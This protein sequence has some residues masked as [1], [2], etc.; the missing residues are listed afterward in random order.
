MSLVGLKASFFV[1]VLTIVAVFRLT[2]IKGRYLFIVLRCIQIVL[3]YVYSLQKYTYRYIFKPF[4]H[5]INTGKYFLKKR[6]NN[7]H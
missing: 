2:I 6:N 5:R 1:G 4:Y 3:F 7:I